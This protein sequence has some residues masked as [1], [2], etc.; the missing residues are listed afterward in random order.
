MALF[1]ADSVLFRNVIKQ[2]VGVFFGIEL[3]HSI[4]SRDFETVRVPFMAVR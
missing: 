3:L 2:R 1:V 4:D